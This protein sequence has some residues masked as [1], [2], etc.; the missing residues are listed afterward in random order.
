MSRTEVRGARVV[1]ASTPLRRPFVTALGRRTHMVNVG[2][3]L[4]LAG[5]A[6]GYGEASTSLAMKHLSAPALARAVSDLARR[7]RGRDAGDWG[8]LT[9]EAWLR[10]PDVSPAVAA[11]EAALLSALADEAGVPLASFFGGAAETLETDLTLS[12]WNDPALTRG[13]AAE[14]ARDGFRSLKIKVGGALAEDLARVRAVREGAPKARL[15]LDGNQGLTPRGA[16]ALLEAVLKSGAAVDLLEQPVRKDDLKGMAFVA[17][18]ASVPVA[19]D[20]SVATPEQAARVLE[21]GAATA[22]NIKLAKSGLSRGLEIAAVAAAAKVPLM[23]GCMAETA[24]GLSASVHFA[25]GTGAFRFVDLDTDVLL[26][27][28][29][30]ARRAAGWKRRGPAVSLL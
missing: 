12:A 13:A 28:P 18:R 21:A 26:A 24:R 20:E 10:A 23:I 3:T 27:E 2:L 5:G 6:V 25:L 11:F 22:I 19:A 16:L 29:A 1:V 15:I 4:R 14:A 7:A 17:R 8:A 30:S 9:S